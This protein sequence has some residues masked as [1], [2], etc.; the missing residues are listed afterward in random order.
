MKGGFKYKDA[1]LTRPV[2]T[3]AIKVSKGTFQLQ[4]TVS[5]KTGGVSL[6][7]PNPGTDGCVLFEILGGDRYHVAFP[8]PPSSTIR[9]NDAKGFVVKE[10]AVEGTCPA[11]CT[12]GTVGCGWAAGDMLTFSQVDWGNAASPAAQLLGANFDSLYPRY[13]ELGVPGPHTFE[14]NGFSM[15]FSLPNAIVS[16]LPATGAN[17]TLTGSLLDPG[18]SSAGTFGGEVVA[19]VLNVDFWDANLLGG[20]APTPLGDARICKFTLLPAVNGQTVRQ[21]VGTANEILG[22]ESRFG[23]PTVFPYGPEGAAAVSNFINNAFVGGT[24]SSF[25]QDHLFVGSS[26]PP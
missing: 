1:A 10:A 14:M 18:S 5:G 11:S 24:P 3:A 21:F 25:A 22:A 16:F 8:A 20:T 7:P 12:P 17:S 23:R 19:L 13:L 15:M 2:K 6:L 9:K 26:C 4:A